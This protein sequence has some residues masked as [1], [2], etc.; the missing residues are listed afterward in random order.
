MQLNTLVSDVR[1]LGA[2]SLPKL[3]VCTRNNVHQGV[4]CMHPKQLAVLKCTTLLKAINGIPLIQPLS[5]KL[6]KLTNLTNY[7]HFLHS[8]GTL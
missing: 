7:F 6:D 8:K 5:M 3:R 1:T 2:T 4:E